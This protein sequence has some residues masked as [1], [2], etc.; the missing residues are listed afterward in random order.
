MMASAG[1]ST[2]T[3]KYESMAHRRS[4]SVP[5]ILSQRIG[6][7]LELEYKETMNKALSAN[8]GRFWNWGMVKFN[9]RGVQR[10]GNVPLLFSRR[11]YEKGHPPTLDQGS[12]YRLPRKEL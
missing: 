3:L 9:R 4:K 12:S 6:S 5:E 10:L 7:K 2:H 1:G 8:M 11:C